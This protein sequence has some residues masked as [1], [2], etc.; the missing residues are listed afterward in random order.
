MQG[1]NRTALYTA[2]QLA[3]ML[4]PQGS[5]W[6]L[7]HVAGAFEEM[8]ILSIHLGLPPRQYGAAVIR[9][10]REM[11]LATHSRNSIVAKLAGTRFSSEWIHPQ[12]EKDRAGFRIRKLRRGR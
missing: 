4:V 10:I 3:K 11:N 9:E 12:F 6:T 1:T 5:E 2:A 8:T 7:A